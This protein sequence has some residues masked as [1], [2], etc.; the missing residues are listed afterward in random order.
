MSPTTPSQ[1]RVF[2]TAQCSDQGFSVPKAPMTGQTENNRWDEVPQ[3]A[4]HRR[5]Q[6]TKLKFKKKSVQKAGRS[7]FLILYRYPIYIYITYIYIYL[8]HQHFGP[9]FASDWFFHMF[10]KCFLRALK[11]RELRNHQSGRHTS[12]RDNSHFRRSLWQIRLL[13]STFSS[14]SKFDQ[15]SLC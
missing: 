7:D 5:K 3:P 1:R 11:S 15:S 4:Q 6:K 9:F 13:E 12:T 14:Q 2:G 10:I 8:R